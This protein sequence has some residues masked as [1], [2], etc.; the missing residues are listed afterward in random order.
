MTATFQLKE[1]AIAFIEYLFSKIQDGTY[2][3]EIFLASSSRS[4]LIRQKF[5]NGKMFAYS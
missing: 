4:S 5:L 3:M 2:N 1:L